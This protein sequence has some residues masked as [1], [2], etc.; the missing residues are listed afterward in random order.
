MKKSFLYQKYKKIVFGLGL[1]IV[2]LVLFFSISITISSRQYLDRFIQHNTQITESYFTL[3]ERDSAIRVSRWSHCPN[4]RV[5]FMKGDQAGL[6]ELFAKRVETIGFSDI[7]ISLQDGIH[8]DYLYQGGAIPEGLYH[9]N[10]EQTLHQHGFH[11][12][13]EELWYATSD[14]IEDYLVLMAVPIHDENLQELSLYLEGNL[15]NRMEISREDRYLNRDFFHWKRLIFSVNID[16]NIDAYLTYHFDMDSLVEYFY[17]GYGITTLV[18]LFFFVWMIRYNI[19]YIIVQAYKQITQFEQE[20]KLISDGD[21]SKRIK[22][23]RYYEFD[24]LGTAVNQLTAM[25]EERNHELSDHVQELYALL[26]QVLEQKD[27]YTRGHSERVAEYAREIALVLGL[28]NAEE[29]HSAGL[30]HDVGKIAIA[31]DLLNKPGRFT[32][33]EYERVKDHARKG[34]DLLM[35]SKEFM[36]I[37]YWV[38]YHHERIDGSGYPAGLKGMEI[39]YEARVIAVAD[40]FDAMTSDRSYRSA[41]TQKEALKF[42]NAQKGIRFQAEIVEALETYLKASS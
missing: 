26:V 28:E 18:I 24:R 14:Q 6:D 19:K 39:P 2:G 13:G 10:H 35:E 34:Y 30:L 31:E 37:R 7:R 27:P 3:F 11:W 23:S 41:M 40:V 22:V 36:R 38:L 8:Q 9:A 1:F 33:D 16:R 20:M 29:I 15:L 32:E 25:I 5:A 21:Y 42:L 17:L 12:V 4:T